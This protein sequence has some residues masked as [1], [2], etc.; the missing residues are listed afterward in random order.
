MHLVVTLGQIEPMDFLRIL[1]VSVYSL[2]WSKFYWSSRGG[3]L[4]FDFLV[5][6]IQIRNM[7]DLR[8]LE[9]AKS[10]LG[11]EDPRAPVIT[12]LQDD[13]VIE[14]GRKHKEVP[15]AKRIAN[16]SDLD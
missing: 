9:A 12:R 16:L 11:F 1:D 8:E 13:A 15:S 4:R 7:P 5:Q 14:L 3:K 6:E 10:W 2:V